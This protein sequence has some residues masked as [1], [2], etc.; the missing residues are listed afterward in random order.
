MG[1]YGATWPQSTS[2]MIDT[3]ATEGVE[4]G[5]VLGERVNARR[6]GATDEDGVGSGE[7]LHQLTRPFG[8]WSA[9]VF[10]TVHAV[11]DDHLVPAR[12]HRADRH[13]ESISHALVDPAGGGGDTDPVAGTQGAGYRRGISVILTR[14]STESHRA[15]G[16]RRLDAST[17]TSR[18][19]IVKPQRFPNG[20]PRIM[21]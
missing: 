9:D 3:D 19:A 10:G 13:L 18:R 2:A 5:F 21:D 8:R 20:R 1:R 11:S 4:H 14:S 6:L 15:S 7:D 16:H 17:A 12:L